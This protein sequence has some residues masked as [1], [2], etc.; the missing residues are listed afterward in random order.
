MTSK[1]LVSL[2]KGKEIVTMY[3]EKLI[4]WTDPNSGFYAR[5]AIQ[6]DTQPSSLFMTALEP[7]L[8]NHSHNYHVLNFSPLLV[9]VV[10]D[11]SPEDLRMSSG[12]KE[13][14]I[15]HRRRY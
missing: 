8:T 10:I 12:F 9:A 2:A 15:L 1:S 11:F 6:R 7:A 5:Y 14:G 3:Q 4:D 13:G